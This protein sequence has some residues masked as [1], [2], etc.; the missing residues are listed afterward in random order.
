MNIKLTRREVAFV[1]GLTALYCLTRLWNITGFPVFTDETIYTYWAWSILEGINGPFV[2]LADGKTPLYIWLLVPVIKL[3]PSEFHLVAGR[4]ISVFAGAVAMYGTV[5]LSQVLTQTKKWAWVAGLVYLLLPMT[6]VYDRLALLDTLL[7]ALLIWAMY[8]FIT[9]INTSQKWLLVGASVFGMLAV[10]TKPTGVLIL[11]YWLA[12][13]MVA[14]LG[15]KTKTINRQH[16]INWGVAISLPVL[17]LIALRLS[18]VYPQFVA[19]NNTFQRTLIDILTTTPKLVFVEALAD[20]FSWLLDYWTLP[21]VIGLCVG[22]VKLKPKI[23]WY[24]LFMLTLPLVFLALKAK[25]IFPRYLLFLSFI[26]AVVAP[27]VVENLIKSKIGQLVG[28]ALGI[29]FLVMSTS[30]NL[31][32]ILAQ[33]THRLPQP[34]YDQFFGESPSSYSLEPILDHI[35]AQ[36]LVDSSMTLYTHGTFG[37]LPYWF[38]FELADYPD[39]EIIPAWPLELTT[40]AKTPM[41]WAVIPY[42]AWPDYE[43]DM[44]V[45]IWGQDPSGNSEYVLAKL[46]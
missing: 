33:P 14:N 32:I 4:L 45:I 23:R 40:L 44:E 17:F 31:Q 28:V 16:M 9:G 34:D 20:Q 8:F 10:A 5:A 7:M 30:F 38:E 26:P 29:S 18:S 2:S 46:R 12:Y 42:S 1:A 37:L 11:V 39:I 35:E 43:A 3:V 27:V 24:V 22:I 25:I 36:L 13:V 6:F 21:L 19:K 41:A 15:A